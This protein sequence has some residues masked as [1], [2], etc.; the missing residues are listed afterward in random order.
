MSADVQLRDLKNFVALAEHASVTLAAQ[1]IGLSQPAMSVALQRLEATFGTQLFVRNR[2]RG[3]GLTPEGRVLLVEARS[4][5][6]RADELAARMSS[7]GSASGGSVVLGSLVTLAPIIVPSLVRRFTQAN[8]SIEVEIQTGSQD[9]LLDWL[10]SGVIHL[11]L[12]Y[13]IELDDNVDFERV[14]DA[15]PH[16]ILPAGHALAGKDS[17]ELT[18]LQSEQY[19]LLDLPLSKDYFS[20]LF[21]AAGVPLRPAR[22]HGDL[23]MVRAMV[24]NGFGYSLVNLLPASDTAL[25]GSE[26]AYVPLA[27]PLSPIGVGL[28]TRQADTAPRSVDG[29]AQFTRESLVLPR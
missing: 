2:G 6:E 23:A 1:A 3:I 26:V 20:S 17:V 29:F 28:V 13:D 10:R 16:A 8:P 25:D 5:L 12:T 11:A 18:N 15:I 27:N 9:Q 21:R 14:V 4:V 19:I 24:G 22:R 7:A